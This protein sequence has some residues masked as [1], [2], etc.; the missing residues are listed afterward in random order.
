VVVTPAPIRAVEKT[1]AQATRVDARELDA[2]IERTLA[3]SE[4][5]W[6]L[7][8]VPGEDAAAKNEGPITRFF[9]VGAEWV[10]DLF[11]WLGQVIRR[12]FRWIADLFPDRVRDSGWT[13]SG[14]DLARTLYVFMWIF[15]IVIVGLLVGLVAM[16]WRR[17]RVFRQ[18]K[19]AA[20]AVAAAVPDLHDENTQ[21]AQLPVDGWL[22]LAREKI[23]SGEW[24]LAWRALHLATLAQL[25]GDG[26]VSLAKFKTNLDYE[27]ELRR[28]A[29]GKIETAA[30]FSSR[31]R[32]FEAA[33]YGRDAA[34]ESV[35]RAW[36]AELERPALPT[37]NLEGSAR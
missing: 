29:A 11:R 34:T 13:Q 33:W 24:R 9:R 32:A 3:R 19:L 4:Y 15:V 23:A 25:G 22:A 28:K 26:L 21:A 2:A 18:P 12:C 16:A 5:Q 35:A 31:S 27:R 1:P 6:R 37:T 10:R 8:P 7:R 17:R 36:L 30:W 14:A 20:E